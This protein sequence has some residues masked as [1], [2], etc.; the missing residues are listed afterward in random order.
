MK[1]RKLG[2]LLV[3]A[4]AICLAT[5]P[6][7]ASAT[8]CD[9]GSVLTINALDL[10]AADGNCTISNADMI[11]M[12]ATEERTAQ[13]LAAMKATCTTTAASR[14]RNEVA[15]RVQHRTPVAT[16]VTPA[17]EESPRAVSPKDEVVSANT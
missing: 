16:I 7:V 13:N 5:V 9:E 6:A 2:W 10:Y 11:L 1:K 14:E 15:H 17:T 3:V 4:G 12:N 8:P